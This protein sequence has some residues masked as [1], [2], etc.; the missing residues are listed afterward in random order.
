M[1]VIDQVHEVEA[2]PLRGH[3]PAPA[4]PYDPFV[5]P[6]ATGATGLAPS[7]RRCV[8][9]GWVCSVEGSTW[10]GGPVLEVGLDDGSGSI[11]I[12]FLGRRAMAGLEPGRR[13]VVAG[14]VGCHRGTRI[15]IDPQ[16]W[17]T[18]GQDREHDDD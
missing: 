11:C 5:V 4:L 2:T 14:M 6:A 12:A 10:D 7:R 17:L 3:D 15:V 1:A 16:W 8:L 13:L 18:G 9:S